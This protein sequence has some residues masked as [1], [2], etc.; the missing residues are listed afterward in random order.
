MRCPNCGQ[1]LRDEDQFCPNCGAPRPLETSPDPYSDPYGDAA[2]RTETQSNIPSFSTG[3]ILQAAAPQRSFVTPAVITLALYWFL[4]F[5]GLIANIVFWNEAKNVE[6]VTGKAPEGYGCL[7]V[8]FVV[9]G[10]FPFFA[11][12]FWVAVIVARS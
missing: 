11:M 2:E 3:P 5:P 10:I 1:E 8:L 7:L 9:F 6:H 4:W 12:C